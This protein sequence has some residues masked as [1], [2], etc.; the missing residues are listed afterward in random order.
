M[1]ARLYC[2][3][4]AVMAFSL[5][6]TNASAD[7][8][9]Y[10]PARDGWTHYG[11]AFIDD[12]IDDFNASGENGKI[13][14]FPA[15]TY[16]FSHQ[17]TPQTGSRVTSEDKTHLTAKSGTYANG[18]LDDKDCF[19]V[20]GNGV[21]IEKI[22]LDRETAT[23]SSVTGN[24]INVNGKSQVVMQDLSIEMQNIGIYT[25]DN[26]GDIIV[27]KC[28]VRYTKAQG[29]YLKGTT[30]NIKWCKVSNTLGNGID[31]GIYKL[32]PSWE[33][34]KV[35]VADCGIHQCNGNGIKLTGY[36]GG[37]T[38]EGVNVDISHNIIEQTA[39]HAVSADYCE[40]VTVS[41]NTIRAAGTTV[42]GPA[43]GSFTGTWTFGYQSGSGYGVDINQYCVKMIV[44]NNIIRSNVSGGVHLGNYGAFSDGPW[45]ISVVNNV[46]S[47]GTNGVYMEDAMGF[48]ELKCIK[49]SGNQI[50]D[51]T[52]GI[53]QDSGVNYALISDNVL[54]N[55]NNLALSGANNVVADNLQY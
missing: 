54:S 21:V 16:V 32:D 34:S 41:D 15:G 35:W 53:R 23:R 18:G 20:L 4:L 37:E 1:K 47:G 36:N 25:S 10:H 2:F 45:Q 43:D 26:G 31:L 13:L 44:A 48:G 12:A 28:L 40:N 33:Q 38:M 5:A 17:I 14:K 7:I 6:A 9:V 49:I 24:G 51:A 55:S 22:A 27:E 52:Y 3:I 19:Y 46:I 50:F 30:L 39:S 29:I 8:M 11:T 42:T